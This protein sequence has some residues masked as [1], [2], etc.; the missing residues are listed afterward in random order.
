MSERAVAITFTLPG[1]R[2]RWLAAGAATGLLIAGLAS[3]LFSARPIVALDP[4]TDAREHTISVGG[5]GRVVLSPDIADLR[6]G[7]NVTATTVKAARAAAAKSMTAVIASLRDL[8][9]AERD[10]QTTILSLQPVYDHSKSSN[11][12]RLVGYTFTNAVA[13]TVRDLALLGD[14]IDDALAAGANS[15]DSVTF[16]VDDQAA[17]EKQ[18]RE[19]AMAEAKAKAQALAAA[20]G[21]SITGVASISETVAPIPYPIYYGALAGASRDFAEANRRSSEVT[22]ETRLIMTITSNRRSVEN[23]SM[24]TSTTLRPHLSASQRISA[25]APMFSSRGSIVSTARRE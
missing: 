9:I 22:C 8:G 25:L 20:A 21:V 4:G 10:I 6:L 11:P 7:V 1:P 24:G 5:T 16:R 18:A 14:A 13:V 17:A 12:P 15:L 2:A 23:S 19:A 3:P